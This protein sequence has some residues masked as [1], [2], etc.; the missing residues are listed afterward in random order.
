MSFLTGNVV[1]LQPLGDAAPVPG[2]LLALIERAATLIEV[3]HEAADQLL[4]RA[5]ALLRG[6]R[7]IPEP[8]ENSPSQYSACT[9]LARWQVERIFAH[10]DSHLD[11]RLRADELAGIANLSSSHFFRCF[12]RSVGV[13]PSQYVTQRRIDLARQLM[14]ATQLPLTQI[15]LSCGFCDQAHF[16]RIFRRWV[17]ETPYVW[18]RANA[19]GPAKDRSLASPQ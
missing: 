12:K 6:R 8:V 14:L 16:T 13:T 10:V 3:D 11:V 1:P 15:A 7:R 9:R 17:G 5:M 18:R 2:T 4:R 19:F